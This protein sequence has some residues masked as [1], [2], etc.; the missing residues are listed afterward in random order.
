VTIQI[1]KPEVEVSLNVGLKPAPFKDAEDV[2]L[3]ALKSSDKGQGRKRRATPA[4]D[5]AL[6]FRETAHVDVLC[7]LNPHPL[8]RGTV[9]PSALGRQP[10]R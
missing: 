10:E 8:E 9:R 5:G 6:E 2:I 7:N 4:G 3:Q 1:T